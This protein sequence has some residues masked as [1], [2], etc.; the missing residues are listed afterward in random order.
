MPM[1]SRMS[2]S[3]WKDNLL[4]SCVRQLIQVI[5][6]SLLSV[7]FM[8]MENSMWSPIFAFWKEGDV[9]LFL[10]SVIVPDVRSV[11]IFCFSFSVDDKNFDFLSS[12]SISMPQAFKK[13]QR[14]A[15]PVFVS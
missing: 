15:K 10:I 3:S 14:P 2:V 9:I 8:G 7:R 5:Y 12:N 11:S 6:V 4:M 13:T 1:L